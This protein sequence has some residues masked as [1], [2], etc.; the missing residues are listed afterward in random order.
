VRGA[1][2]DTTSSEGDIYHLTSLSS[3]TPTTVKI[4]V[5]RWI[6]ATDPVALTAIAL[7]G[8]GPAL[9]AVPGNAAPIGNDAAAT[10]TAT[11]PTG[12]KVAYMG[13]SDSG[14]ASY[15]TG[16]ARTSDTTATASAWS[17]TGGDTVTVTAYCG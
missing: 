9:T 16:L 5:V 3:P 12:T 17:T 1:G 10:S 4:D 6:G 2:F 13:Y 7:C 8:T 11:C 14:S 15:P